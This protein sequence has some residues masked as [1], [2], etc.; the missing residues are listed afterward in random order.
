MRRRRR[1]VDPVRRDTV[2]DMGTPERRQWAHVDGGSAR[3]SGTRCRHR[4]NMT[5]AAWCVDGSW[6][7]AQQRNAQAAS[8]RGRGDD[9][10]KHW[11]KVEGIRAP[12]KTTFPRFHHTPN[13]TLRY[14]ATV[15]Q[16]LI[17][18]FSSRYYI[19]TLCY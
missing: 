18:T 13:I 14:P 10:G 15:A 8:A 11:L 9:G 6:E 3:R 17:H 7:D 16:N 4:Q 2:N 5:A 1:R 12:P 19:P